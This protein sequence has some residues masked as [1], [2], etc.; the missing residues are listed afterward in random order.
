MGRETK[1]QTLT[2]KQYDR[3]EKSIAFGVRK[4]WNLFGFAIYCSC[5]P[6][7]TSTPLCVSV[8]S[9]RNVA[10]LSRDTSEIVSVD[11]LCTLEVTSFFFF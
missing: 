11:A 10:E 7:Y 8:S 1:S 3:L 5:E 6:L 9:D 2:E 4:V